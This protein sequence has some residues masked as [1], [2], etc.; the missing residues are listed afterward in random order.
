MRINKRL[1]KSL[2][3]K[4]YSGKEYVDLRDVSAGLALIALVL[5]A[6]FIAIF[7]SALREVHATQT[8]AATKGNHQDRTRECS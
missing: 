7:V 4:D 8:R 3:Q 5:A 1:L 6:M 2:V